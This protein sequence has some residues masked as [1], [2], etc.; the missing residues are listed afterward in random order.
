M[1]HLNMGTLPVLLLFLPG[2]AQSAGSSRSSIAKIIQDMG[3]QATLHCEN[4]SS[5]LR[6]DLIPVPSTSFARWTLVWSRNSGEDA[7][8]PSPALAGEVSTQR[9]QTR[10]GDT[11]IR[12]VVYP[13]GQPSPSRR[14]FVN[15]GSTT[16]DHILTPEDLTS[17]LSQS[18]QLGEC[19]DAFGRIDPTLP[20]SAHLIIFGP[21]DW[22]IEFPGESLRCDARSYQS[23]AQHPGM[24][25]T[26]NRLRWD[27]FVHA[28]EEKRM[29]SLA[30]YG[31]IGGLLQTAL[32]EYQQ[33]VGDPSMV[34]T[35]GLYLSMRTTLVMGA[36]SQLS[37]FAHEWMRKEGGPRTKV[38]LERD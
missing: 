35:L 20:S 3:V 14:C 31:E 26:Q 17:Q 30:D 9:L 12:P 15:P 4:A 27:K 29:P 8:H 32:M 6:A 1:K 38:R 24:R 10:E 16:T 2:F 25:S 22:R 19:L 18:E 36:N 13:F 34:S 33:N 11:S 37:E 21:T 5:S 28:I 7:I 23:I